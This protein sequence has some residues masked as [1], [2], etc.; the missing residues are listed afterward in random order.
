MPSFITITI[1]IIIILIIDHFLPHAGPE[2][3]QA[4]QTRKNWTW[5]SLTLFALS[6]PYI[7]WTLK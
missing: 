4:G 2:N 3:S 7:H 1:I 5:L 6:N